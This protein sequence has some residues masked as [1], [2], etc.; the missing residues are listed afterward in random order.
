MAVIVNAYV[1]AVVGVPEIVPVPSPLSVYVTPA[2]RPV[3]D[4]AHVGDPVVVTVKVPARPVVKVAAAEL[5]IWHA[6]LTV[7]V[8]CWAVKGRTTLMLKIVN[9]YVPA[10][11][12]VPD[13]V[14]VPYPPG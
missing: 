1:P 6:W 11:V 2:G 9:A 5:V 12:G 4:D 13:N 10:V 3:A 8:K 14:A 7:R